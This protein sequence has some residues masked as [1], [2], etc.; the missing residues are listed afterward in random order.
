MYLNNYTRG[1]RF[2][3]L[4]LAFLISC[5]TNAQQIISSQNKKAIKYYNKGNNAIGNRDFK[6]AVEWA[7]KAIKID[8]TF[9]EAYIM[10]AES[11]SFTKNCEQSCLYFEK[12]I[13]SN[14]EF[15]KKLYYFAANEHMRC[16]DFEKAVKRFDEYFFRNAMDKTEIPNA[17]RENYEL[18]L[19]RLQLMKDSLAINPINMGEN[20][21]SIYAEYLP[22]LTVD[23]SKIVFT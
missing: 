4:S 22:S 16:G 19:Y 9:T 18:C 10:I 12:A 14:P 20:V 1:I 23:E 11:Y 6:T 17:V 15:S 8:E 7:E 2:L 13:A 3:C 21:N 5:N